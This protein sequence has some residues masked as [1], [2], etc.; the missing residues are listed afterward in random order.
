MFHVK[1]SGASSGSPEPRPLLCP[2]CGSISQAAPSAQERL[3]QALGWALFLGFLGL[4]LL[5]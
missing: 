5:T 3:W 2:S 4:S 1:P